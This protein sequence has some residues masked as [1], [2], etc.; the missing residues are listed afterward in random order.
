MG[1]FH[2]EQP[3]LGEERVWPAIVCPA[4]TLVTVLLVTLQENPPQAPP[5]PAIQVTE[6]RRVRGV[7]EVL[8]PPYTR[9]IDSR[10]DDLQTVAMRPRGLGPDRV[11]EL[12]EALIPR[13]TLA[14]LKVIA[15]EVEPFPVRIH[16]P[17]LDRMQGQAG[18]RRPR[19]H[20]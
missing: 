1:C 17:G 6:H 9:P 10:N 2:A 16:D 4:S 8:K 13:P 7:L 11:F 20:W 18:I 12:L 19:L 5:N 3:M 15:Q 14:T